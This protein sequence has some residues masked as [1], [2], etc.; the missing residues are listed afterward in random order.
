M[1]PFVKIDEVIASKGKQLGYLLL[2]EY[3]GCVN[4]CCLGVSVYTDTE[5]GKSASHEDQE[6]FFVLEGNGK[7]LINGEEIELEPGMSFIV[8]A[9]VEHVMKAAEKGKVCKILWFHAA[10]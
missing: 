6:G 10:V 2:G 7:A 4:G 5:Y 3:E 9:G 1:I 8:P